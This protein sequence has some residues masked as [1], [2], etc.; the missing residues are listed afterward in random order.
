M[1]TVILSKPLKN[2]AKNGTAQHNPCRTQNSNPNTQKRSFSVFLKSLSLAFALMLCPSVYAY[3]GYGS[4]TPSELWE[5]T[6]DG[7]AGPHA[8][9][10]QHLDSHKNYVMWTI[11]APKIPLDL[12]KPDFFRQVLAQNKTDGIS[13]SHNVVAWQ[14]HVGNKTYRGATGHS[15]ESHNQSQE[16]V[17]LGWGLTTFLATFTDGWLTGG[18]HSGGMLR[19]R[20]EEEETF[21][22]VV[23][24]K[25]NN[26]AQMLQFLKAFIFHPK[27][28]VHNFGLTLDPE[29][30]EGAG[31]ITMAKA[32]LKKAGVFQEV[33]SASHRDLFAS[34]YRFGGNDLPLPSHTKV[35]ELK[36]RKEHPKKVRL[37]EFF[38]E[39]WNASGP[40]I[41]LGLL[42]PELLILG[43]KTL[44]SGLAGSPRVLKINQVNDCG[45]RSGR[46]CVIQNLKIDKNLDA[47]AAN[48]VAKAQRWDRKML[49]SGYSKEE[50]ALGNGHPVI[51]YSK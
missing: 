41:H 23:E 22:L 7:W 33:F 30:F 40:G 18:I 6:Q 21:T 32:L 36:W 11:V 12:R 27:K 14:C 19:V 5:S 4:G 15:G 2:L 34:L 46:P 31:C 3:P 42:D 50:F 48:I 8:E 20:A 49:R 39:N 45:G 16:M 51:L 38:S 43:Y 47:Q 28:P 25:E 13:I 37:G 24:V 26:C 35:P 10:G 9:I 44:S 1:K 17:K 29:K